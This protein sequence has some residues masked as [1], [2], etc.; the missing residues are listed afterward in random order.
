MKK[1]KIHQFILYA[2]HF[3]KESMIKEVAKWAYYVFNKSRNDAFFY[4]FASKE[5]YLV[6]INKIPIHGKV[7]LVQTWLIDMI[8]DLACLNS[9]GKEN[10]SKDESLHLISL[11]NDYIGKKEKNNLPQKSNPFLYLYGFFGEQKKFQSTH[12]FL[13]TFAREKYILD[14]ISQ[15][16]HSLNHYNINIQKVFQNETGYST[17][18]YSAL[19][20]FIWV[21]FAKCKFSTDLT[22]SIT[23]VKNPLFENENVLKVIERYSTTIEE[24]KNN[25]FKRQGLYSKPFIKIKNEYISTN[26]F[27][28][29]SLF[30][31][32]L[33]WVIR[34]LYFKKNSLQFTNAFGTYFEIYV[35]EIFKNCLSEY[36]FKKVKEDKKEKRADWI[37]NIDSFTIIIE[38]KSTIASIEAKQNQ[39]NLELMKKYMTD[40][41]GEAIKQLHATQVSE[42]ISE[43]IKIILVYEDYYKSECLDEVFSLDDL[44]INDGTYWLISINEFEMLLNTYRCNPTLGLKIIKEKFHAEKNKTIDGRELTKFLNQNGIFKNNYIKKFNID[45]NYKSIIKRFFCDPNQTT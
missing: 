17:D 38:Q 36:Q 28:L 42:N 19:V 25:P 31:N 2:S 14:V 22:N 24:L 32:C 12:E 11:Y 43:C 3:N 45:S 23:T 21:Y 10:I 26:P 37:L 5:K 6:Y 8:Y 4:L 41:W 16:K 20:F 13:D 40:T 35:E 9:T 1:I 7:T 34:N 30:S 15:K 39:P 18:E 29:L 44:P 27:L 33:Y